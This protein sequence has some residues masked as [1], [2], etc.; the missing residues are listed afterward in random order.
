MPSEL[1]WFESKGVVCKA[2]RDFD[3][4][5]EEFLNSFFG[6]KQ[7]VVEEWISSASK[8][9]SPKDYLIE[10]AEIMHVLSTIMVQEAMVRL[11]DT[12]NGSIVPLINMFESKSKIPL[13]KFEDVLKVVLTKFPVPSSIMPWDDIISL[14][15]EEETK[16]RNLTLRRWMRKITKENISQTELEE[17]IDW[18]INDYTN[19]MKLQKIKYNWS[20]LETIVKIPFEILEN[21]VK[22]KWSKIADPIFK[23]RSERIKSIESEL[24]VPSR[25]ISYIIE[26][27]K[28]I[29]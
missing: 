11:G 17:E 1:D 26:S 22:I 28:K 15:N 20:I 25:E 23:L 5:R 21:I 8:K 2:P 12:I 6:E 7:Y 9:L 24:I 27:Q 18:L 19:Y 29:V 16:N 10:N 4:G 13:L 14:R 3:K